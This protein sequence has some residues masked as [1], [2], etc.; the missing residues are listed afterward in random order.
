[1]GFI[2]IKHTHHL[3]NCC[4]YFKSVLIKLQHI[5]ASV[6]VVFNNQHWVEVPSRDLSDRLSNL[7]H[8][9]LALFRGRLETTCRPFR[10]NN[11][12][13]SRAHGGHWNI[14]SHAEYRCGLV[15]NAYLPHWERQSSYNWHAHQCFAWSTAIQHCG[16]R[17]TFGALDG[18]P[19]EWVRVLSQ[20]PFQQDCLCGRSWRRRHHFLWREVHE[21]ED[22]W[23]YQASCQGCPRQSQGETNRSPKE[24][25]S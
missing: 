23:R 3:G 1:M 12:K 4:C 5:E 2:T 24:E 13:H 22:C 9:R 7:A 14:F 25:C 17:S 10:Q 15:W 18:L 6:G 20:L 21:Q 16:C 8:L 19:W 11:T